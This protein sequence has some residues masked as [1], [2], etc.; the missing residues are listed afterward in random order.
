MTRL[1][2]PPQSIEATTG[3]RDEPLAFEWKGQ[4]H[5][6]IQ[7]SNHWRTHLEWWRMEIWRDYFQV[8]VQGRFT[9]V[10]Y[11]DLLTNKWYLE[12]IYD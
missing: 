7:L 10:V 9:C 5:R 2:R 4:V 11:R 8:E 3:D 12:R 6:V 1:Y